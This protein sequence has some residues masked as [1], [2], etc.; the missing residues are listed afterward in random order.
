MT[1]LSATQRAETV[2]APL[3]LSKEKM[4]ELR[5]AF[6]DE[7]LRGLEMHK[8]HGLKWVPEEC[9]LRMLDSCVSQI[10]TGDEVGVFYA[11]DFGGTNVRAVRC[12]LV[13]GGKIVSQQSLK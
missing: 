13:G 7:L 9:S 3:R 8:K 12:E 2:L 6:K 4:E 11:L 5:T 1:Q 10:P